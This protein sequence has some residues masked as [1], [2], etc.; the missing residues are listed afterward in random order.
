MDRLFEYHE[1]SAEDN[2]EARYTYTEAQL[3]HTFSFIYRNF[4]KNEPEFAHFKLSTFTGGF[5]ITLLSD[6]K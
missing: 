4:I 6:N 2:W 5:S 1:V 3:E